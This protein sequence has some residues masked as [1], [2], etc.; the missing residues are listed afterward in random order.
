MQLLIFKQMVTVGVNTINYKYADSKSYLQ[1]DRA[2][3]QCPGRVRKLQ[4]SLQ[5]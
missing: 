4:S 1:T 5:I 2:P 3:D